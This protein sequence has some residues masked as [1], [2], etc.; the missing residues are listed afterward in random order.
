MW[1]FDELFYNWIFFHGFCEKANKT[2]RL[3]KSYQKISKD[4]LL[5][6]PFH[7]KLNLQ[8]K[9][10]FCSETHKILLSPWN[11]QFAIALVIPL[12]SWVLRKKSCS[13][14]TVFYL[15]LEI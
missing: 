6:A 15:V 11:K 9:S 13:K 4:K 10:T 3:K 2:S 8:I 12:D 5:S 1:Q 7:L 14:K